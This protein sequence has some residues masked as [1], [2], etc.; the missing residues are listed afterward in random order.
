M[1]KRTKDRSA[2]L[3]TVSETPRKSPC[4]EADDIFSEVDESISILV[5]KM[6]NLNEELNQSVDD[7]E[8]EEF[9]RNFLKRK[10]LKTK[11]N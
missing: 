8:N 3:I 2:F 5:N 4:Q 9:S 1:S 11:L 10:L 6:K 7:P